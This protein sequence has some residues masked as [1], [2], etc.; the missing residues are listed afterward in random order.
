M[1]NDSAKNQK[2]YIKALL[3]KSQRESGEKFEN[4]L[5]HVHEAFL[6][7]SK[8]GF[9][10]G[11][12]D[13]LNNLIQLYID[14]SEYE[15]AS[16]NCDTLMEMCEKNNDRL[17][18]AR[19]LNKKGLS[20]WQL[21]NVDTALNCLIESLSIFREVDDSEVDSSLISNIGI[22]YAELGND[23]KSEEF[24]KQAIK[25]AQKNGNKTSLASSL[26]NMGIISARLNKADESI[27][28]FYKAL[29]IKKKLGDKRKII[30]SLHNIADMCDEKNEYNKAE[31]LLFEAEEMA[32][33]IRNPEAMAFS[34]REWGKHFM[35]KGDYDKAIEILKQGLEMAEEKSLN[36]MAGDI[37]LFISE[38]YE[39]L[40]DYKA[41]LEYHKHHDRLKEKIYRENLKKNVAMI[42]DKYERKGKIKEAEFYREKHF[43]LMKINEKI[44]R[45]NE[46]LERA[47]K[48]LKRAN[49]LLKDKSIKD[50]LTGLFN[51]KY[52]NEKLK[53][54]IKRSRRY[55]ESF[56]L[57]LFDLDDFKK[58]NDTFGHQIGDKVLRIIVKTI[59]SSIREVDMAFRYGGEEFLLL[60]PRTK[61]SSAVQVCERIKKELASTDYNI[62]CKVT[63]SGG[64][65][66]WSGESIT[67][68]VKKADSLLYR[69]KYE[70]K[71][72]FIH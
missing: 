54:E 49:K 33:E 64:I 35:F 65:V 59:M 29:E 47:E 37:A 51:H 18:Y 69:A 38:S 71:N 4:K 13:A 21:G 68:L 52:M 26:N 2:G 60:F 5:K 53:D 17:T 11:E 42:E 16:E 15:K 43:E 67:E 30:T 62:D 72:R 7:S 45:Q 58:I 36:S 8:Q 34:K 56:S 55:D 20:E 28:Y 23:K 32:K 46:M 48:R 70:G 66:Q 63:L 3:Q 25:Q 41:A 22:M 50:S 57:A 31:E 44:N 19:V 6:L 61:L 39:K 10:E 1:E 14:T 9:I 24:F 12:I 27:E 40:G